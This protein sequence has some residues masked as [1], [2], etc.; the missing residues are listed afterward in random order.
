MTKLLLSDVSPLTSPSLYAML[1]E[2]AS[3]ER[4]ARA[5]SYRFHK[6]RRL[7]IGAAALLDRGL[8]PFGLREKDMTYGTNA[9]GKPFF[10]NAPHIHFSISHSGTKLAVAFSDSEVGCDI[11]KVSDI[12]MAVAE[13]F[14]SG[15]E[16]ESLTD[17]KDLQE[18]RR[19]FF[20]MWTL[21]ESYMKA[22]GKG[23]TLAPQS[24]TAGS[25]SRFIYLSPASFEG[26]ECAL[27]CNPADGAPEI[28]MC[29]LQFYGEL[30]KFEV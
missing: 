1:Y 21:K 28:E 9:F 24:F 10:T 26:Y 2:E 22:T 30:P 3:A 13:R 7:S 6:D 8:D 27:C 29:F 5:D 23:L 15:E 16:Y 12:D 4:R 19:M 25:D 18:R 11:E 17:C 20:R 14:F